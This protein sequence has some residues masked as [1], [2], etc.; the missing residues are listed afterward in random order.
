MND[1]IRYIREQIPDE[2][3]TI[4]LFLAEDSEFLAL[5]EDHDACVDAFQYWAQSKAPEAKTR[6]KE[7]HNLVRELQEEIMQ[8]LVTKKSP[9][10]D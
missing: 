9:Q 2:K 3:H 10:L 7:Y 5:C 1:R 4:N 8:V 6:V